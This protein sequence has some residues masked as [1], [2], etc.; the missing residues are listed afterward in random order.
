[1]TAGPVRPAIDPGDAAVCEVTGCPICH[2]PRQTG[3]RDSR[4]FRRAR[5]HPRRR[6][7]A[8]AIERDRWYGRYALRRRQSAWHAGRAWD[9]AEAEALRAWLAEHGP[10]LWGPR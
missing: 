8:E 3:C 5:V 10:I 6:A 7:L 4:G 1:M 9:R 2:A